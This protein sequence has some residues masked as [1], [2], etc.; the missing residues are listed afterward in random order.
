METDRT[1]LITGST[2]NLGGAV[3]Q[4]FTDEDFRAAAVNSPRSSAGVK[5]TD[6][7]KSFSA[8]LLDE[9]GA[10]E[11]VS[12]VYR[13]LGKV[14][15][16]VLTV[17]G[18]AMGNLEATTGEDLDKMY[19]LNFITSY[20]IAR[21]LFLRMAE[22]EGGGQLVFI[23]SRPA[24]RADQAKELLAYSLSKSLLFRL[25]EVINEEGKAHNVSATVVIPGIIDTPQNRTAMPDADFSQWVDPME[26]ARKIYSLVSPEGKELRGG[27]IKVYGGS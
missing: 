16:G 24:I 7:I 5:N 23:G 4:K 22:Q 13:E 9:G 11:T 17:G 2:G 6:R 18:F 19:R 20:N 26:I 3:M 8:D 15:I 10:A 21:P 12:S 14:D 27:I 1:I 25:A